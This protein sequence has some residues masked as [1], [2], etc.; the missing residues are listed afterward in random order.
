MAEY[1]NLSGAFGGRGTGRLSLSFLLWI[2]S[3]E[4]T[5]VSTSKALLTIDTLE[6]KAVEYGGLVQ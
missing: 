3:S 1:I 5:V 2:V 6:S 4:L